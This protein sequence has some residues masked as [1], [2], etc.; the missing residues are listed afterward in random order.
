MGYQVLLVRARTNTSAVGH[1]NCT[2]NK[3][4]QGHR[5][6]CHVRLSADFEAEDDQ[7]SEFRC[8]F[9][10]EC[11]LLLPCSVAG[12]RPFKLYPTD[13]Q[14]AVYLHA[15][16]W[17]LMGIQLSKNCSQTTAPIA[18]PSSPAAD[19]HSLRRSRV[20]GFRWLSALTFL[21][22]EYLRASTPKQWWHRI[23]SFSLGGLRRFDCARTGLRRARGEANPMPRDRN[24]RFKTGSQSA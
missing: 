20:E 7:D 11:Q 22:L 5:L 2:H 19:A 21:G 16:S 23:I 9:K 24:P 15:R 10:Y 14:P 6:A 8:L 17:P 18:A 4:S 13:T 3:P 12:R 1:S